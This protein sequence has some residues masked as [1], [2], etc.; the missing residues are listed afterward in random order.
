MVETDL[1]RLNQVSSKVEDF[2][3]KRIAHHDKRIPKVLPKFNEVDACLDVLDE[4][5]VKYH[6][7]FH[8]DAMDSLMPTYQYDWKVIFEVPWLKPEEDLNELV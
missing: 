3:D 5:Y 8:A 1:N 2:A 7:V 4:L 6:L